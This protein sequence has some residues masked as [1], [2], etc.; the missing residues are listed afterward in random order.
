MTETEKSEIVQKFVTMLRD[1][2]VNLLKSI[3]TDDVVWRPPGNSL[4]SGEA[5]GVEGIFERSDN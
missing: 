4:I 5:Y 1:G 2:D 3:V